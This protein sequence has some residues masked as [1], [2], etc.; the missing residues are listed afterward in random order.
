MSYPSFLTLRSME[1]TTRADAVM[2]EK[3]TVVSTLDAKYTAARETSLC[4]NDR[5]KTSAK[6]P[7]R[8]ERI[9]TIRPTSR[10]QPKH[11]HHK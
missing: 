2:G 9:P 10:R 4:A 5:R 1:S 3:S 11:L 8:S 6:P 7:T